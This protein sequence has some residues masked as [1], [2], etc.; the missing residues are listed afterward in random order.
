MNNECTF[1]CSQ[2]AY[3]IVS[4]CAIIIYYIR[5]RLYQ[6][7]STWPRKIVFTN[8]VH[9]KHKCVISTYEFASR[10]VTSMSLNFLKV[11]FYGHKQMHKM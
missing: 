5:K 6:K 1:S 3:K 8:C 10:S 11:N 9:V 2:I 7:L 4:K